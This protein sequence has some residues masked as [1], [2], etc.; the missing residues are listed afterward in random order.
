MWDGCVLTKLT[1]KVKHKNMKT[2]MFFT[3]KNTAAYRAVSYTRGAALDLV[4]TLSIAVFMFGFP[5][6]G[7]WDQ[8]TVRRKGVSKL[9]QTAYATEK[10][11]LLLCICIHIVI[12]PSLLLGKKIETVAIESE[13]YNFISSA[14]SALSK[15]EL[16]DDIEYITDREIIERLKGVED[17]KNPFTQKAVVL[18]E[19]P[20]NIAVK[21]KQ[22]IIEGIK[23]FRWNG[24]YLYFPL[25][26]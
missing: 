8:K 25:F 15:I 26:Q 16:E 1:G 6:L 5:I 18:E 14:D 9:N 21:R 13:W 3:F 2:D 22:G 24:T 4:S 7:A 19:S 11:L 23:L 17:L 10:I 20:G 12:W